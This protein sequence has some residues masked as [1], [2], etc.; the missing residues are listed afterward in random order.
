VS[1]LFTPEHPKIAANYTLL[2]THLEPDFSSAGEERSLQAP[3]GF[4][5][6]I[7]QRAAEAGE[8]FWLTPFIF[9][10]IARN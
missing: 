7:A 6:S 8:R 5:I 10:N 1:F 3:L 4:E 2:G 9:I